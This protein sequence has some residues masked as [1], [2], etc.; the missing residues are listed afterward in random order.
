[1]TL[2]EEQTVF[3]N[4]KVDPKAALEAL[5]APKLL[6]LT[7]LLTQGAISRDRD[8]LEKAFAIADRELIT[9]SLRKLP[10]PQVL[11]LLEELGERLRK[12]PLRATQLT[13]WIESIFLIHR[14]YLK[15]IPDL[16]E[17]IRPL[18]ML[19]E[20][21][22]RNLQR[23]VQLR[24]RVRAVLEVMREQSRET[25]LIDPQV[26]QEL[27]SNPM[28]IYDESEDEGE[29]K[30]SDLSLIPSAKLSRKSSDS[31][32]RNEDFNTGTDDDNNSDNMSAS[33]LS[34]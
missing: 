22:A 5:P 19:A 20:E 27:V 32:S 15:T 12:K 24:G 10:H 1:M 28:V 3:T 30:G 2:T 33:D 4:V 31:F 21:R 23:L 26:I 25:P 17:R 13:P 16:K 29:E 7:T 8:L 18:K 14:E 6:S 11:P 34:N 9:S